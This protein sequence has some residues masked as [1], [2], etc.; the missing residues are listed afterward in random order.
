MLDI[1]VDADACPV[2]DE[3]LRVAARHDLEVYIVANSYMRQTVGPKVHRIVVDGGFDAADNWI[4]EHITPT[5]IC[6]T[7]DIALATRAIDKGAHALGPTGKPF[8]AANIG[9]AQAMRDLSAHLRATGESR[10]FNASF[11][12]Q[13]RSRFLRSLEEIIQALK[14]SSRV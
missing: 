8:T 3:V 7:A 9:M 11:T 13:D 12:P 2:K 6:I 14:R 5:D 10:G 4:A 1:Y